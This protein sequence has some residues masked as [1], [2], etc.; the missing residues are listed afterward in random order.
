PMVN[1]QRL[2]ELC[3]E[4]FQAIGWRFEAGPDLAP[5]GE[6]PARTDYR[7]VVLRER[8][9]LALARVNPSIPTAALEQ[10][11]HELLTVSEP[12]PIARNR[13][14]HRLLLAGIP[15]EFSIGDEKRNDLVNL[16]D[17]A[18]PRNNDFLL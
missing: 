12:L 10:A 11:A 1:E 9:L 16:I 4:W 2:E 6:Q 18:E 5:D 17:F 3:L 13:R 8:L 15:V 14:V 7:Q